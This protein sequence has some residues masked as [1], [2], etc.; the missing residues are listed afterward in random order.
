MKCALRLMVAVMAALMLSGC[1][2]GPR[3]TKANV[4]QVTR[5]NGEETGRIDSWSADRDR[6]DRSYC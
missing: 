4:D 6:H 2:V 1:H 5:R 3:L